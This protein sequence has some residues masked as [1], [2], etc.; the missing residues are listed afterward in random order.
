M[1]TKRTIIN[2]REI[3]DQVNPENMTSKEYINYLCHQFGFRLAEGWD[4]VEKRHYRANWSP[5]GSHNIQTRDDA[6]IFL[7]ISKSPEAPDGIDNRYLHDRRSNKKDIR[8]NKTNRRAERERRKLAKKDTVVYY[9]CYL[10]S[11][12]LL[13]IWGIVVAYFNMK[14]GN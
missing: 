5:E 3:G 12:Y 10:F 6:L 1:S 8:K 4:G 13:V 2:Y 9:S 14:G 7:G 11:F